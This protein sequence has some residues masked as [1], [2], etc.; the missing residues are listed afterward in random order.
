MPR[1]LWLMAYLLGAR[2]LEMSSVSPLRRVATPAARCA[3]CQLAA[4]V[5]DAAAAQARTALLAEVTKEKR[6]LA[7]IAA[8]LGVLEAAPRP[9]KIK[10]ALQGDWKLTF[11]SDE[12]AVAPF[13]T[14]AANGPFAVLEEVYCRLLSGDAIN[15]VEVVRKI[16]P[17]GNTAQVLCGRFSVAGEKGSSKK[18]KS[19]EG[20]PELSWR[21]TYMID[22]RGKEVDIPNDLRDR[23]SAFA[24]HVSSD[25]MVMRIG[26]SPSSSRCTVLTTYFFTP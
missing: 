14:G 19:V 6:S 21:T 18:A 8:Q 24:T 7:T 3:S 2:A 26:A 5:D 13:A 12:A 17:F 16:G 10:R 9:S 22:E 4:A 25:L 23:R 11:A 15:V 1:L 20:P